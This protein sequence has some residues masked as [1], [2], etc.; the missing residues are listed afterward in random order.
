[1]KKITSLLMAVAAWLI[2]TAAVADTSFTVSTTPTAYADLTSGYYVLK[3][4]AKG[5][6]GLVYHTG[7]G[8][9][10]FRINKSITDVSSATGESY[11]WYITKTDNGLVIQNASDGAYFPAGSDHGGNFNSASTLANAAVLQ[12]ANWD[13]TYT[14]ALESGFTLKEMN[15]NPYS[16]PLC[17]HANDFTNTDYAL[18][19]WEGGQPGDGNSLVMFAAYSITSDYASANITKAVATKQV[20]TDSSTSETTTSYKAA[21]AGEAY[22][23]IQPA[24]A[25]DVDLPYYYTGTVTFT[26]EDL[27]VSESNCTFTGTANTTTPT[28]TGTVPFEFSTSENATWYTVKFRNKDSKYLTHQAATDNNISSAQSFKNFTDWNKFTGSLWAFVEDGY[29]VKVLCKQ[30]GTYLTVA[31][32][33]NTTKATL[34]D[35]G[36]TFIVKTNSSGGFSLKVKDNNNAY[37]GDHCSNCLGVWNNGNAQNDEGSAWTIEKVDGNETAIAVGK[38]CVNIPSSLADENHLATYNRAY[39]N[40]IK[41]AMEKRDTAT[42]VIGLELAYYAANGLAEDALTP[43][44]PDADAYYRI[45]SGYDAVSYKYITSA[46]I[47]TDTNG[48]LTTDNDR[49]ITRVESD[50]ALVPM[51]WQFERQDDGSYAIRNANN[52]G[53]WCDSSNVSITLSADDTSVG[54]YTLNAISGTGNMFRIK[55]GTNIINA[56][57]GNSE[58][59]GKRVVMQYNDESDKGCYW[60]IEKV[61]TVPVAISAA[62]YA[63]V[64]FPFA[65]QV[66]NES[67]VKAYYTQQLSNGN[68]VLTEIEDGIIPANTGAV[69]Y[70]DGA[71]TANLTITATTNTLAD[72]KLSGATARRTGFSELDTYVL[73]VDKTTSAAAFCKSKLTAVPANKAY[74]LA[75]NVPAA[76]VTTSAFAFDFHKTD[77]IGRISADE[78]QTK[79]YDL[80]G[81]AVLYPVHGIYVT[82]KGQKVLVP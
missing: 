5:N 73:A 27:T 24:I 65:V 61:T 82:D 68:M 35:N 59:N 76:E 11:V 62:N 77:G 42:T 41:D 9:S 53:A 46:D 19:Y 50:G 32:G 12:T 15:Y 33:N 18:N 72:N 21:K 1:M 80:N 23:V 64:C 74:L 54:K 26:T 60:Q 45:V 55:L 44:T 29:G 30:T 52:G 34:S 79:Y 22:P 28:L 20:L 75:S 71:T 43:E 48:A 63:S 51:L 2:A 4:K 58:Y 3:A 13:D 56:F 16:S 10:S 66:D 67:G 47:S 78:Q 7:S 31:N 36:S 6:E 81:R 37:M 69:L 70:H 49:T 40:V 17:I 57:Y 25:S 8:G 38:A 14:G 39:T